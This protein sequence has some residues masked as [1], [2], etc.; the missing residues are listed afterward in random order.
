MDRTRLGPTQCSAVYRCTI[1]K[2][3]FSS[4]LTRGPVGKRQGVAEG[5]GNSITTCYLG[6]VPPHKTEPIPFNP[7][8]P[9]RHAFAATKNE[10][11]IQGVTGDPPGI[12]FKFPSRFPQQNTE[13]RGGDRP[14]TSNFG[15]PRCR[16][17]YPGA[18][19]E[20][21]NDT[22]VPPYSVTPGPPGIFKSR[23]WE[24]DERTE[25]RH[26]RQQKMEEHEDVEDVEE[27]AEH[28]CILL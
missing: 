9:A 22:P 10:N 16:P 17:C 25:T 3:F 11:G 23:R 1:G 6:E 18:A 8:A 4:W 28:C 12:P 19:R 21:E 27:I 24:N 26:Q 20:G 15:L 7:P 5:G 2:K 14:S 13:F